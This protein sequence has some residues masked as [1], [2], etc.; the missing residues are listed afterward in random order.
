MILT[1]KDAQLLESNNQFRSV[2]L[3]EKFLNVSVPTID[4]NG[5]DETLQD[6]S[7]ITGTPGSLAPTTAG[8]H[9]LMAPSGSM[10]PG[11]PVGHR[12]SSVGPDGQKR[13]FYETKK[14]NEAALN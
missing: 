10:A 3:N 5:A 11:G 14:I 12:T 8:G 6:R 1:D 13:T 9:E 7:A 2:E 4:Q